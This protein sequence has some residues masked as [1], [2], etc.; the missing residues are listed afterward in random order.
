M[1]HCKHAVPGPGTWTWVDN[2]LAV[3]TTVG[4]CPNGQCMP[5][6]GQ[7]MPKQKAVDPHSTSIR[8]VRKQTLHAS[9]DTTLAMPKL[10]RN[11]TTKIL[12][13][14]NIIT[15]CSWCHADRNTARL[16]DMWSWILHNCCWFDCMQDK[17]T[18][19][20]HKFK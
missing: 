4:Q 12:S 7:C 15:S 6:H 13:N 11:S 3:L 8:T 1:F 18:T 5:K 17:S 10:H 14:N 9:S 16:G 20:P 19:K 2:V